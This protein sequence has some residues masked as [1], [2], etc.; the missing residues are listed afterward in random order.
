MVFLPTNDI[1]AKI[2][3]DCECSFVLMLGAKLQY[4]SFAMFCA[5]L[6]DIGRVVKV[7][8]LKI[9]PQA[10]ILAGHQL[11]NMTLQW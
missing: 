9:G 7:D 2:I 11:G 5:L 10:V 4:L 6:V 3:K 1:M 8:I